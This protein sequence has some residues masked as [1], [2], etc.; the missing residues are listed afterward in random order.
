MII[1]KLFPN[2]ECAHIVRNCTSHK[3]SHSIHGHSAK[4]ELFLESDHL[5]NAQMV[6]DFGLLGDAVK[7]FINSFDHTYLLCDRDSEEFKNLILDH[8]ERYI[9]M[10][11]NPSAEMLSLLLHRFIQGILDMTAKK[12]GE[13]RIVVKG[14][15]YHETATGWAQSSPED[16]ENLWNKDWDDQIVF[17]AGVVADWHE[18]LNTFFEGMFVSNPEV[19]QQI[20]LK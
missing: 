5:D 1:R 6:Y 3:C 12:N 8:S 11:F 20:N 7:D 18:N 14:V 19:T 16:V 15:R 4:I 10:P 13:D 17:S 9:V 2:I